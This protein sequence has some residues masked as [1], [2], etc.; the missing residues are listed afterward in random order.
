MAGL[1]FPKLTA[2]LLITLAA[3]AQSAPAPEPPPVVVEHSSDAYAI[4]SLLL[5]NRQ[6]PTN[7]G[8]AIANMT[9]TG[10]EIQTEPDIDHDIG[11]TEDE[12]TF[13]KALQDFQA[14]RQDRVQLQHQLKI[15]R[16]YTLLTEDEVEEFKKNLAAHT[17]PQSRTGLIL[18]SRVSF[19]PQQTVA[20]LYATSMCPSCSGGGHW[21]YFEKRDGQW[22]RRSSSTFDRADTYAIYSL[23]MPG[24]PFD[25]MSTS[26]A[27]H[28]AIAGQTLN[29]NDMDPAIPP[30]G[31][32]QP[33]PDNPG[34]FREAVQD[35]YTRKYE[36]IVID[37]QLKLDRPYEL[38][39]K[40]DIA[41]L[42]SSLADIDPGSEIK[43]KWAGYPGITYFSEVYFDS[44]H[45]AALVYMNNFCATLCANGQWVYLEK[46]G[47]QWVRRSGLNI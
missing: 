24:V 2:F 15:D 17:L 14:H 39:G 38:L 40:T 1:R 45:K 37:H 26:Q 44:T 10:S 9:I 8:F 19:D 27:P 12:Q 35:F 36:R 31:Q 41:E 11:P 25:G 43:D 42:K 18:F 4:Y 34:A 3:S 13:Q 30:D 16:P 20:L 21:F 32:L 28:F 47:E 33:P 46:K 29:I 22:V 5:A 6:G 23:L 7:E